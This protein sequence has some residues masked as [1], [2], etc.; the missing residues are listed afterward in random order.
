MQQ[1]GCDVELQPPPQ[2]QPGAATEMR[3]RPQA[4]PTHPSA[5]AGLLHKVANPANASECDNRVVAKGCK[6]CKRIPVQQLQCRTGIQISKSYSDSSI[7]G[8]TGRGQTL[9]HAMASSSVSGP[10]LGRG[11]PG[12]LVSY[13]RP[14][15][16]CARLRGPGAELRDASPTPGCGARR[17]C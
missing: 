5:T 9:C 14:G 2:T 4:P 3:G 13:A 1:P 17:R 10:A 15:S 11:E 6:P 12:H 16:S 7:E 8:W